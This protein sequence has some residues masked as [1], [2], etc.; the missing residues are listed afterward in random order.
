LGV[1]GG[2]GYRI[3]LFR[4]AM[5]D[6]MDITYVG[7]SR[8]GPATV[9][10]LA[11]PQSHEGHS[12][13]TIQQIDNLVQ[14]NNALGVNPN[15]ILLHIGTN[16]M[17]STVAPVADADKRLGTLI[18]HITT[19][20]PNAL[21]VV[22]NII[23]LAVLATAEVPKYNAKIPAILN[24]RIQAGKNIIF[25]DQFQGF[26]TSEL[27]DQVH[28]NAAGYARM[29]KKWYAAIKPYLVDINNMTP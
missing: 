4:L 25:V 29:A 28:P 14:N 23:P 19:K 22:S 13:W 26:P 20:Q 9:D 3:E 8:N 5:K 2:G 10:G 17:Y 7:G 18:D 11:F 21:L 24:S 12:G 15:I 16:D 6:G 27:A 1:T